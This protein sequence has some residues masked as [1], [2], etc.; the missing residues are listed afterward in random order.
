[1]VTATSLPGETRSA[2][3]T[4][5]NLRIERN[6]VVFAPIWKD[7]EARYDPA[8]LAT[9]WSWTGT[10]L[11]AYGDAIDHWVVIAEHDNEPVGIALLTRGL[12]QR[13][14]PLPVR[15]F[16]IGTAGEAPGEGVW[17]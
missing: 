7:L 11:D 8:G 16:H 17:I 12:A 14:G 6:P 4:G 10:W 3:K 13:R 1:M 15:T 9:S 5:L 2:S